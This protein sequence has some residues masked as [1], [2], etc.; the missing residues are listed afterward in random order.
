MKS[1]PSS[2][3][4][5]TSLEKNLSPKELYEHLLSS[6][7]EE[8]EILRQISQILGIPMVDHS[9]GL[10]VYPP[11]V[12]KIPFEEAKHFSLFVAPWRGRITIFSSQPIEP[13]L[14]DHLSFLLE[15]PLEQAFLPKEELL[16]AINRAYAGKTKTADLVLEE[17]K[18]INIESIT[19]ELSPSED[20]MD[21]AHKA[22]IVKLVNT[23]LF[24]A[25]KQRASDIHIQPYEQTVVVRYRIDGILYTQM[26]LPKELQDAV[27]SRIKVMAKMDIAERRLPQ[28]GG[29]SLTASGRMVD[30]R[31][32]TLP[33]AHGERIVFRLQ[34]KSSGL[35]DLQKIGLEERQLQQI[36]SLIYLTHGI[37]LVTGPTGSGKTT[38]LYSCLREINSPEKNI[39]TIEDPIEYLLE[40]ISQTQVS[41]KKGLTF[42]S[43][44]R[45]IVRQDPDVIMIGEIRDLE[46]ARIAI[47]SALTGHLVF[48]TLH[49]ND[50][51]GAITRLL[52]IGIEPYLVASSLLAVIAQRLVRQICTSCKVS[53]TPTIEEWQDLGING[54]G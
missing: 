45:S 12:T 47:Q 32:S 40:G 51:P 53:Y 18:D 19:K 39:I 6:G 38:T 13:H 17:L 11:F 30:V 28:D 29:T 22:P 35:Y 20:L 16:Q 43:G 14:V 3:I 4:A 46:T 23:I 24:Q 8:R 33:S 48:S 52:D 5:E 9:E 25:L 49:T 34:D 1:N 21:M 7:K 54:N 26:E 50:A 42:A 44:L 27:I 37:I 36:L 10:E 15:T 41:V 31:I 2:G